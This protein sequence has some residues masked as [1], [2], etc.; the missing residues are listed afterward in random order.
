MAV[1]TVVVLSLFLVGFG[2]WCCSGIGGGGL[3]RRV[4]IWSICAAV[5]VVWLSW[6]WLKLGWAITSI[7]NR[8]RTEQ[9]ADI[10]LC[11]SAIVKELNEAIDEKLGQESD[12]RLALEKQI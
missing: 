8:L 3:T 10:K 9:P 7:A 1:A 2:W 11:S 6:Y 12:C 4:L 5:G